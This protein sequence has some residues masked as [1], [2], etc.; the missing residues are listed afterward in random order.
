LIKYIEIQNFRSIKYLELHP[1]NLCGLIGPNSSGKTNILK[2]IDLVLGEGWTTKAK[3][4]RELFY[5]PA[6][7]IKIR[8][9]FGHPIN[10]TRYVQGEP[11]QLAIS[12]AVLEMTLTPLEC[13]TRLYENYPGPEYWLNDEFKKACHFIHVP[14]F[15]RL[16]AEMR[17]SEWTLLGKLMRRVYEDYA[18]H[19]GGHEELKSAFATVMNPPKDFLENDFDR[20]SITFHKF[21]DVFNKY[22][23]QN[24]VGLANS[25]RPSL[26]IYNLNWFYKTL[27]IGVREDFIEKDFEAE[28]VGS[29]MQ[30]LILL[31]IFQTYA[32][33]MG[34]SAIL[35]IEEPELFLYPQAQRKLFASMQKLSE[36]SQMF[37]TTHSQNFVDPQRADEIEMVFKDKDRGTYVLDKDP[38]ITRA[39]LQSSKFKIYAHFNT[40][41]NELFFANKILLVEGDADKILFT[42]LAKEKWGID[43]DKEGIS[44]VEC[45]GKT[46]VL[47]FIGVCRLLGITDFFAVWDGDGE[48]ADDE[49]GNF[50][51]AMENSKAWEVPGNMDDFLADKFPSLTFG[52][53]KKLER[54]FDW[55][56]D[57]TVSDIPEEFYDVKEFL[58]SESTQEPTDEPSIA[59]EVP[60]PIDID[61]IP[62]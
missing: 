56:S 42:T 38:S 21:K 50:A 2:A 43:L 53:T 7:P 1:E 6:K 61:D 40:E 51:Q 44:V 8:I 45:G 46:G 41:R 18:K 25:F 9:D 24:S 13:K 15:R 48:S 60:E 31:S 62:F 16:D 23:E 12:T 20:T 30:N 19:Y 28:E 37:Y 52:G 3:V 5:D 36:S 29:G 26:N 33:L 14:S 39:T 32:E 57:V 34:G 35:A 17:V 27:Q 4:A 58:A 47:Y 11:Q 59:I 22:C 49:H 55:A 54:A 10:W